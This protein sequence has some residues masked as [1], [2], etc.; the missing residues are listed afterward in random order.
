MPVTRTTDEAGRVSLQLTPEKSARARFV[1]YGVTVLSVGAIAAG[2]LS[3]GSVHVE[4]SCERTGGAVGC[5]VREGVL[6]GLASRTRRADDV[7]EV[8]LY[9]RQRGDATRVGLVT[10]DGEVSVLSLAT[11]RNAAD[12][13][14]L[15]EALR[16][17][18]GTPTAPS[19]HVS[20]TLLNGFTLVGGLCGAVWL[21]LALAFA[22]MPLV[23]RR[24]QVLV[25][26]ARNGTLSMRKAPGN[27]QV[28][29]TP[30]SD[31][32]A[33]AATPV[34]GTEANA[35]PD[36]MTPLNLTLTLRSGEV[37]VLRNL[38]LLDDAQMRQLA[39]TVTQLL[40]SARIEPPTGAA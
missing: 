3:A 18:L 34:I 31:V 2:L 10:P 38:A 14:A 24:P 20:R 1:R 35:E 11:G 33:V 12:K 30:L 25:I 16:E 36:A 32:D 9:A 21:L 15:V 29:T 40:A 39:S 7:R 19:L 28:V 17:Y 27:R 5:E 8:A 23:A 22:R 6:W 26:D 13:R 4:V 37:L